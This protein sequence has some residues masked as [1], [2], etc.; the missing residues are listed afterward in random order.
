MPCSSVVPELSKTGA[1]GSE[2]QIP[3]PGVVWCPKTHSIQLLLL[4]QPLLGDPAGCPWNLCSLVFSPN[5]S[6]RRLPPAPRG[7]APS[8][9]P[10]MGAL[11]VNP[12]STL[13]GHT[14]Q[15]FSSE[16]LWRHLGVFVVAPKSPAGSSPPFPAWRVLPGPPHPGH[17]PWAHRSGFR[18]LSGVKRSDQNPCPP[19]MVTVAPHLSPV[20]SLWL[21]LDSQARRS[22][23]R[24]HGGSPCGPVPIIATACAQREEGGEAAQI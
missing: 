9:F 22:L 8:I 24:Q 7:N 15:A 6:L 12:S 4:Q 3:G 10:A 13:W 21:S 18:S 5:S 16:Q 23:A 1:L 2:P 19:L 20:S 14:D 17:P 11:S